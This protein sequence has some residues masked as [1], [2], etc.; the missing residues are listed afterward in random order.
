MISKLL[1]NNWIT[2]SWFE[3]IV[4]REPFLLGINAIVD[5]SRV[6]II[7]TVFNIVKFL[8]K[9]SENCNLERY[10]I[11]SP[12]QESIKN[13]EIFIYN[14]KN[15]KWCIFELS[16]FTFPQ[17]LTLQQIVI[18]HRKLCTTIKFETMEIP[19][20]CH[21]RQDFIQVSLM[22]SRNEVRGDNHTFTC[23]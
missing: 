22:N 11:N 3:F 13:L 10:V 14:Q 5:L 21:I 8:V 4:L 16:D 18:N 12:L 15:K 23:T 19:A 2:R 6:T 17:D 1:M 9:S 20:E 7:R